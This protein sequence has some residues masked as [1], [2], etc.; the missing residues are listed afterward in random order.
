MYRENITYRTRNQTNWLWCAYIAVCKQTSVP[1]YVRDKLEGRH[2]T[3]ECTRLQKTCSTWNAY[4][5]FG[6]TLVGQ[7][8]GPASDEL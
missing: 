5:S 7:Q 3:N 1:V 2:H 8:T 6:D 4:K